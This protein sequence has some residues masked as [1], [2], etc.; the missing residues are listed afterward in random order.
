MIQLEK[1]IFSIK[2]LQEAFVYLKDLEES[3]K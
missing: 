2:M 1:P 3:L